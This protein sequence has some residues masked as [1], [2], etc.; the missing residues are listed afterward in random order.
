[1]YLLLL[2]ICI[3]WSVENWY[4]PQIFKFKIQVMETCNLESPVESVNIFLL[5]IFT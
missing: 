2:V 4:F 5:V 1:M 3:I